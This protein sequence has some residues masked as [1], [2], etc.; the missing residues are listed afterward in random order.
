VNY[1]AIKIWVDVAQFFITGAIGVYIYLVNKSDATNERI[2]TLAED[3]DERLD[4][5]QQRLSRV[6]E[7]IKHMPTHDDLSGIKSDIASLKAETQGQT[8]LLERL[9]KTV[10]R[11]SD[12][13]IERAK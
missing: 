12:W 4:D 5:H 11:I 1:D 9:E 8:Q 6:E 3:H 7:A 2:S 10:S 13:L